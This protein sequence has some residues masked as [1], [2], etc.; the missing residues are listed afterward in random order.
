MTAR[1]IWKRS[2]AA[3][4]AASLAASLAQAQPPTS[5][6]ATPL[7]QDA[8]DRVVVTGMAPIPNVG[9]GAP[10]YT[11]DDL[12]EMK[13]E[14]RREMMQTRRDA[15]KCEAQEGAFLSMDD[16]LRDEGMYGQD[17]MRAADIA[18]KATEA[19]EA[20]RRIPASGEVNQ[21]KINRAELERQRAIIEYDKA[22]LDL[23]NARAAIS[24]YQD[25]SKAGASVVRAQLMV[26]QM[27]RMK[28][29]WGVNTLARTASEEVVLENSSA[30]HVEGTKGKLWVKVTGLIRNK[31][32][33]ALP[34]P[35][36]T[37]TVLDQRGWYLSSI[38]AETQGRGQKIPAGKAIA[39]QY[40]LK[41]IPEDG[42]NLIVGLASE[43]DPP[44]RMPMQFLEE[45]DPTARESKG[46]AFSLEE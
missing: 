25:L 44:P 28:A 19:A 16:L 27:K 30:V 9:M 35:K 29:G 43:L 26:R 36:L 34:I 33:K 46:R 37:M 13:T 45:C 38:P 21:E 2:L 18:L 14:T 20:S 6:A 8:E 31:T 22:R 42:A 17:V 41:E 40:I 5:P 12:V 10:Y 11:P 4:L 23:L 7:P 3:I 24:D 1:R 32:D 39:F 15:E